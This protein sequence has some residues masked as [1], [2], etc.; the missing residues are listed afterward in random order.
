M[1]QYVCNEIAVASRGA[2]SMKRRME[3]LSFQR[4]IRLEMKV[5]K[6]DDSIKV[7]RN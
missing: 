3:I 1:Y 2:T 7:S 6:G 5:E 4:I